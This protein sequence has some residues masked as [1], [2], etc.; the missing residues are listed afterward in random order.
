MLNFYL[1]PVAVHNVG[2]YLECVE[3]Y[4]Y[5]KFNV[6]VCYR[7]AENTVDIVDKKVGVFKDEQHS[8]TQ[9][10]RKCNA[11]LSFWSALPFFYEQPEKEISGNAYQQEYQPRGAAPCVK[12]QR[13][14][15][16]NGVAVGDIF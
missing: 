10:K 12:N 3:A 9:D 13:K 8:K 1:S 5:R 11:E 2:N 16:K 15:N 6:R 7:C 4:A 14:Y